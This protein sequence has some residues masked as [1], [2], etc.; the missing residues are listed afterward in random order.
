M[1]MCPGH[2]RTGLGVPH[3]PPT[4]EESIPGVADTLERHRGAG[5]R[6]VNYRD[7]VVP[8]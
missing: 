8:W 7:E 5:L 4:I 3:A 2:V 6:F 1:L